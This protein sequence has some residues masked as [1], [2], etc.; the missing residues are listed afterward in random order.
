MD[1]VREKQLVNI[2]V[3]LLSGI[4]KNIQS[5]VAFGNGITATYIFDTDTFHIYWA[6]L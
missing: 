3:T 6:G 2:F 5:T 1:K 4:N